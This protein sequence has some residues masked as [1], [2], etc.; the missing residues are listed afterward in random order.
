MKNEKTVRRSNIQVKRSDITVNK[1]VL[2]II[3]EDRPH[4]PVTSLISKG[5]GGYNELSKRYT[6]PDPRLLY[7]NEPYGPLRPTYLQTENREP[8]YI[9]LLGREWALD[10]QGVLRRK[11]DIPPSC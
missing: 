7:R 3:K 10:N 8:I 9:D 2:G 1:K 6:P 5:A 11:R 4:D